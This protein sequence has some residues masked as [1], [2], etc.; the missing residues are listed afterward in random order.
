MM[1]QPVHDH[2]SGEGLAPVEEYRDDVLSSVEPLA[3]IE[4]HLQ[5]ALGC[6]AARDVH[7]QEDMPSFSSSAMDG[8]AVRS[9]DVAGAPAQTPLEVP[10]AG[11][12]RGRRPPAGHPRQ[13]A[14]HPD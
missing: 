9:A 12:A 8:F 5:E 6:V 2:D 14:D 11:P 7:A 4:L 1:Q 10:G 13:L 3:P